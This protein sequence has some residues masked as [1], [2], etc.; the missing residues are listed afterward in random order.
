MIKKSNITETESGVA[1]NAIGA[2]SDGNASAAINTYDPMLQQ[3]QNNNKKKKKLRS[4]I[5]RNPLKA[6]K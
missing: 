5:S 4:I 1:A 6:I 3:P 2:P